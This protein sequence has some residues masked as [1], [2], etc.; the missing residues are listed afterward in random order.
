MH[1]YMNPGFILLGGILIFAAVILMALIL[2]KAYSKG[3][4]T[5]KAIIFPILIILFAVGSALHDGYSAKEEILNNIK[6][7]KEGKELKCYTLG[8]TYLISNQSGWSIRKDSFLKDTLLIRADR[9]DNL[10]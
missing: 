3:K 1:E 5:P 8:E 9:C 6:T 10:Q 4:N 7:Y 2:G